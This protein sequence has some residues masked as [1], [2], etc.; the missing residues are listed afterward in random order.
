MAPT[1]VPLV[2]LFSLGPFCP[3]TRRSMSCPDQSAILM[4]T[5]LDL[6]VAVLQS[7]TS[8]THLVEAQVHAGQELEHGQVFKPEIKP[9]GRSS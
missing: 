8:K 9:G 3:K 6:H 2:R 5:T 1:L 7:T 4:A